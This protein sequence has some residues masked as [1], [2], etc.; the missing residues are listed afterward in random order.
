MCG[1]HQENELGRSIMAGQLRQPFNKFW[2]SCCL[3]CHDE[4]SYHA[5]H[6][7]CVDVTSTLSPTHR[8]SIHGADDRPGMPTPHKCALAFPTED[9]MR[10]YARVTI[11]ASLPLS[12][13]AASPD[14]RL[15]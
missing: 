13:L 5:D 7:H 11:S 6:R 2:A 12:C 14:A 1:W 15:H 10:I 4:E 9:S 3:V 8:L